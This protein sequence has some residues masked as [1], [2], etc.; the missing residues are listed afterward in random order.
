M[1]A[2]DNISGKMVVVVMEGIKLLKSV[3]E[4]HIFV[5]I[6]PQYKNDDKFISG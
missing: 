3:I 4:H 5:M 1:V 6:K 2:N